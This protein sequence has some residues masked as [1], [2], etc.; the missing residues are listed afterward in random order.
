MALLCQP[1]S[2][3][4]PGYQL[5]QRLG[6]GGYGEVWKATAPGGL[7]KAIKIVYGH[8][9]DARA[10]QELKSLGR[11]KEV[12]HPFILSLE[13]YE[14]L[15]NQLVIV[16]ELADSSLLD[17]FEECKRTK[18]PG[19]P[20]NELL[21]Y[22]LDASDALDYMGERYGL[23]HLDIKPQNLLLVGGRIKLG[24]FGL[25]K[26]LQGTSTSATGGITAVYATPE[27][28]DGRVSRYSDQY[29]LAIVYQEMLTGC[30]PFPGTTALQLAAQHTKCP[31]WLDSLSRSDRPIIARALSKIPEQRFPTCREMVQSL[32]AAG[33]A[34]PKPVIHALA[35]PEPAPSVPP[36]P[37]VPP[38]PAPA[39]GAPNSTGGPT[40]VRQSPTSIAVK[41][42]PAETSGPEVTGQPLGAEGVG[43]PPEFEGVGLNPLRPTLVLGVGGIASWIL[44]RL[45]QRLHFEGALLSR[46]LQSMDPQEGTLGSRKLPTPLVRLLL[47]D[48]D[49]AGLRLAEQREAGEPL[50]SAETLLV[51]L[52][53]PEHYR[54]Q[55]Q[56]LLRSLE[57]RWLYNIPRSLLTGGARP[58]G[59]LA[60]VDNAV[61][62]LSRLREAVAALIPRPEQGTDAGQE[63][64][65]PP[66]G[67][68]V[69]LV[70]SI[71]GGTG[72]GM[73]VGLGYAVQQI[74]AEFHLPADGLCA[75]LMHATSERPTE[76][77]LARLNA[78]A[79]L[80]ELQH[81]SSSGEAY[82]GDP[83]HGLLP[84]GPETAP[85]RDTYI[86]HLGDQ[87]DRAS[88]QA[89]TDPVADY[90]YLS[91]TRGVGS[92][93]GRWREQTRAAVY[94]QDRDPRLRLFGLHRLVFPR[95]PV[96]TRAAELLSKRLVDRW[97]EPSN[98]EEKR[99]EKEALAQMSALGLDAETLADQLQ[100]AAL[101]VFGED[102]EQCFQKI[103]A[104]FPLEQTPPPGE[105]RSAEL[106]KQALGKIDFFLGPGG[107]LQGTA[108][109]TPMDLELNRHAKAL[110]SQLSR[111][112]FDWLL[113]LVEDP[114]R[115][116]KAAQQAA[117]ASLSHVSAA[118]QKLRGQ[119]AQLRNHRALMRSRLAS[120][121]FGL[122]SAGIAWLAKGRGEPSGTGPK[123][124]LVAYCWLRL[125]ESIFE[126][127]LQVFETVEE[128]V[129]AFRQEL[130][131]RS[132]ALRHFAATLVPPPSPVR[133]AR[134]SP[135]ALLRLTELLPGQCA[136]REDAARAIL[137]RFE[138][139]LG[140]PFEQAVQTEVLSPQGG[141]WS[142]SSGK[143]EL[144]QT[145]K[146]ELQRRARA[147]L[148][149]AIRDLDAAKL[150]L[151]SRREP[152]HVLRDLLAYIAS[153]SPN[154]DLPK[155]WQHLVVA[156]PNSPAGTTVRQLLEPALAE[157]PNSFLE[158]EGEIVLCHEVAN[159]PLQETAELL[160]GSDLPLAD[161][162][163]QMLTRNDVAWSALDL[164]R[165]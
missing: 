149:D 12:R 116:F 17:R 41:M 101:P 122:R 133:A 40:A 11:I 45:R 66:L 109:G 103:V 30:R 76:Q 48:T 129:A 18:L 164:A 16:M 88:V 59:R 93:L 19:I 126:N 92:F 4:I 7:T 105:P 152:D 56:I 137:Q 85:F 130:Q 58:L 8:M 138:G 81:F 37:S 74:L 64:A 55:S 31:P 108:T 128:Q 38:A 80:V 136:T 96:A 123:Q 156:L 162:A 49:R 157:V 50:Q 72:G 46:P 100:A 113:T 127:I 114:E 160:I 121:D 75:I 159:L 57:R 99:T 32:L 61:E 39:A 34:K 69:I 3:P 70:A 98:W 9:R 63:G 87:L 151:E 144:E 78:Y 161:A 154:R 68:Q 102:P 131:T 28:F 89:A 6:A 155:G 118:C 110:A 134:E 91:V 2:E 145:I 10:E 112:I 147:A 29:S 20:R 65:I 1:G 107:E 73:V 106:A 23:Q 26:D 36:P 86:A 43:Q 47:L 104:D 143:R 135:H 15:D 150:L 77:E 14:I 82:P 33:A 27:A 84:F 79:T 119:V 42:A 25:V 44:R 153:V 71:A 158:S 13:R 51:P 83:E 140:K 115:R 141:L 120:G 90:L 124:K 146:R 139:K 52:R 148:L 67:L 21:A 97:C 24:D 53:R 165:Q 111:S 132:E 142:L 117:H 60:L 95:F 94:G 54:P 22:L 35:T 62:V 5:V 163:R 125:H